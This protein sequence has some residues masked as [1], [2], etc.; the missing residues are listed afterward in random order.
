M[1]FRKALIFILFLSYVLVVNLSGKKI[2]KIRV[3]I[4]NEN[5]IS[6]VYFYGTYNL[7]NKYNYRL[8]KNIQNLNLSFN[9]SNKG[10]KIFNIGIFS[11]PI[12]LVNGREDAFFKIDNYKYEGDLLIVNNNSHLLF[13]NILPV[14][15]YL[16]GVLP[17][18]ISPSWNIEVIKAQA[19]A[20]R[21]FAYYLINKNR[22]N[23]YD[24]TATTYSQVYKGIINQ[25]NI[26][27]KAIKETKNQVMVYNKELIEAFFHSCCGGHTEDAEKVWGKKLPYLRGVPCTYC[28]ES[29][30]Y[31]WK[32]IY[33]KSEIIRLLTKNGYKINN[34]RAIVPARRSYSGR[35]IRVRIITGRKHIDIQA[36][37]FRIILGIKRLKSTRFRIRREGDKFIFIGN[38]WGHGVGMCQWGAKKMAEIGYKYY[39][40]LRYYYRGIN[41]VNIDNVRGF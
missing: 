7:I 38:G 27:N 41:I 28:R 20:A 18:E 37:R 16:K 31:K 22:D 23:L 25:N 33:L 13:I 21:T 8:I 19:V 9:I 15:V 6:S 35:W 29:P 26:F 11:G 34:I 24:L 32:V 14:E 36:N 10:I 12:L 17:N 3:L 1:I 39:Q 5:S 30:Y 40:I 4:G 2:H